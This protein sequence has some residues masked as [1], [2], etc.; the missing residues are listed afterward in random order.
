MEEVATDLMGPFPESDWGNKCVLVVVDS[1]FK[2]DGSVPSAK[3][4]TNVKTDR[5]VDDRMKM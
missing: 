1:F 5:R 2:M 4:N 3:Q